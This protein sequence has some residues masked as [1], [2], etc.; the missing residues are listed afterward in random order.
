VSPAVAVLFLVV[1]LLLIVVGVVVLLHAG[2]R[3]NGE[4]VD[5]AHEAVDLFRPVGGHPPARTHI[6]T[7]PDSLEDM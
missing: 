7:A 6:S 1:G 5:D 4:A 3:A 2:T